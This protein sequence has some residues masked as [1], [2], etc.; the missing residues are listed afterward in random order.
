MEQDERDV[1]FRDERGKG[2][3]AR[4]VSKYLLRLV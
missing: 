4:R 3:G 1:R 2:A